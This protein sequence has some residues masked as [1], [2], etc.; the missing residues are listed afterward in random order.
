[1]TSIRFADVSKIF[2]SG[3]DAVCALER[4]T[5][6]VGS[7]EMVA[8]LG[9]SGSGKSTLIQI[10]G[11]LERPSLGAVYFDDLCVS[12]LSDDQ[13]VPIRAQTIGF[14]FQF[15]HLISHLTIAENVALPLLVAGRPWDRALDEA[16]LAMT[17]LGIAQLK[18]RKP[19]QVSGGQRQR[20]AV[21][22][23]LIHGPTVILADEPTGNLDRASAEAV[24]L[25][26]QDAR[27]RG[28]TVMIVTHDEDIARGC[29]RAVR[30]EQGRLVPKQ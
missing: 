10:A 8:L 21:A 17:R 11:A 23:A 26:L 7:G 22:R 2:G 16:E 5:F 13:R 29:D 28:S 27:M 24:L 3:V 4:V 6:H 30:L 14:V 1:M 25:A 20:A 12:A 18:S 9:G 15:H 19:A